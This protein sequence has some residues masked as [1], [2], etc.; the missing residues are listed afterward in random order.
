MSPGAPPSQ[1]VPLPNYALK[2][3]L[4]G[5]PPVGALRQLHALVRRRDNSDCDEDQPAWVPP[6]TQMWRRQRLER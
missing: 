2:P 4:Q 1:R 5:A 6:L 3:F